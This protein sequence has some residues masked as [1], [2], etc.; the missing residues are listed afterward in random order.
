MISNCIIRIVT[1]FL[2]INLSD[3]LYFSIYHSL[4]LFFSTCPSQFLCLFQYI[5]LSLN[6]ILS[7]SN[8]MHCITLVPCS[9]C[10]FASAANCSALCSANRNSCFILTCERAYNW[11]GKIA[12]T[13][14][15]QEAKQK[16]RKEY[17][18]KERQE[19][20]EE[21]KTGRKEVRKKI[22]IK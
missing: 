12:S 15:K 11:R 6:L 19:R 10:L 22:G 2:F 4:S 1:L 13:L 20:K 21:R 18:K 8:Y 16:E 3:S 5:S 9:F 7:L 17:R 14:V